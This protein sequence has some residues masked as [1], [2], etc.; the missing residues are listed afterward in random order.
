MRVLWTE[1]AERDRLDIF[2][3]I[4]ASNR[5]A[6][7]KMDQ[8]FSVA[9]AALAKWPR[10]APPGRVAGTRELLVHEHYLLIYEID[11]AADVIHILA[12]LHTSRCWPPFSD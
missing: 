4:A 5:Y 1:H 11:D 12:V 10:K 3:H 2:D 8:R 7:V 6:A 9:A